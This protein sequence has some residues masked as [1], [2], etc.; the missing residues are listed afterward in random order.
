MSEPEAT[1]RQQAD[2]CLLQPACTEGNESKSGRVQSECLCLRS[3]LSIDLCMGTFFLRREM[4]PEE[5]DA[6]DAV[7]SFH[8][9]LDLFLVVNVALHNFCAQ[10]SQSEGCLGECVSGDGTNRKGPAR[11]LPQAAEALLSYCWPSGIRKSLAEAAK[12][13]SP[14]GSIARTRAPPCAPVAPNTVMIF[15]FLVCT[16]HLQVPRWALR[17]R[18]AEPLRTS[19][20]QVLSIQLQTARTSQ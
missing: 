1:T 5:S 7:R 19:H 17:N 13:P 18:C 10:V 8:C 15:K 12:L 9:F 11:V 4:V 3:S 14:R 2:D 20:N 6:K 16:E